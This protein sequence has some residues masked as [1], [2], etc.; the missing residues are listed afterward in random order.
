MKLRLKFSDQILL[1]ASAL[2]TVFIITAVFLLKG[3]L[4]QI[5][6]L[7]GFIYVVSFLITYI[8]SIKFSKRIKRLSFKIQEMAAGNLSK[9]IEIKGNDEIGQ[10]SNSLNELMSRLK[11]GVAQN[12]STHRELAQAKSDFVAIASHQLRTPLSIVKWYIDYLV[13]GDAG[14]LNDE[15]IKYLKEVYG[16]NERLIELVNALLDVSRID[17]GTFSIEPEPTDI[18]ERANSAIERFE[19]EIEQKNIVL[20]KQYDEFPLLKLDPRL[21]KIVFQTI[22]SN[23]VKYTPPGGKIRIVVKKTD[24]D[25][26]IKVSDTGIG[27][28][29]EEQPKMFSKLFRAP[30]AK[31][32]E[33][34]GTG[35]GL[36]IVKAVIEKSGGKIWLESPSLDLLLEAEQEKDHQPIDKKNMGT[37]VHITIPL[38]GMRE[39]PGTKKLTSLDF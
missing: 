15:Q 9:K 32:I 26:Y 4:P 33:S 7:G 35:L 36:Y 12:V 1:A 11:T 31:K 39:K 21:T 29:R 8:I 19:K 23:A 30:N 17:V 3:S 18:I 2:A 13:S 27:I 5:L 34:V 20:E 6:I 16:S 14:A 28:T 38:K 22:I 25:I 10:L 37:T 24:R